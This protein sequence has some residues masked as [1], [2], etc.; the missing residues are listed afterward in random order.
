MKIAVT[1]FL[2][3]FLLIES[4]ADSQLSI[5]E[6]AVKDYR[7]GCAQ[8]GW[9]PDCLEVAG[10]KCFKNEP[11]APHKMICRSPDTEGPMLFLTYNGKNKIWDIRVVK[12]Q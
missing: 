1:I 8:A 12:D 5:E 9:V 4:H 11:L 7:L 10:Y 6:K 2:L 3:V